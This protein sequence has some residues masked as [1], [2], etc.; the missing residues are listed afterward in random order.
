MVS[1][2]SIGAVKLAPATL[3]LEIGNT[4]ETEEA[5]KTVQRFGQ[6]Q[7]QQNEQ[8]NGRPRVIETKIARST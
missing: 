6:F 5:H 2:V 1:V 7:L 3:A 4:L 8:N